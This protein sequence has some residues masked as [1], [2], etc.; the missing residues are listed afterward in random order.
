MRRDQPLPCCGHWAAIPYAGVRVLDPGDARSDPAAVRLRSSA[1]EPKAGTKP[2]LAADVP[3][4]RRGVSMSSE[5]AVRADR[6]ASTER[7]R[8]SAASAII[9]STI[10]GVPLRAA[11]VVERDDRF[12]VVERAAVRAIADHRVERVGDR[13]DAC[14]EQTGRRRAGRTGSRGR[15]SA[16]DGPRRWA[17]TVRGT[18]YCERISAPACACPFMISHSCAS[19][20]LGLSR[21]ASGTRILPMSCRTPALPMRSTSTGSSPIRIAMRRLQ[22]P[23]ARE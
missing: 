12:A 21:I 22:S 16:R 5:P 10:D 7:L 6:L 13:D 15:R 20:A 18:G 4:R 9:T 2:K 11:A 3:G 19:R 23:V 14:L 1:S 17:R 8:S